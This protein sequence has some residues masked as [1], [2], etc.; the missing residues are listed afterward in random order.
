[1]G[2][3]LVAQSV[4]NLPA[5]DL[6][7]I[8]GSRRSP[9]EGIGYPLRYYWASLVAQMVKNPPTMWETWFQSLDWEDPLEKGMATHFSIITWRI[10]MDRGAWWAAVH[11]VTESQT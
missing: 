9:G 4:K 1:M 2:A 5:G 7:S 11:G 3:S 6:G 10:P 8:S